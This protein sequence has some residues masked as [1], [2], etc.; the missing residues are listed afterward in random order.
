MTAKKK[1]AGG[2]LVRS[3]VVTVRLDPKLKFAAELAARKQRRTLSSFI[4][5]AIEQAVS[6]VKVTSYNGDEKSVLEATREIWDVSE[7]QRFLNFANNYSE[8]LNYD[9]E[10]LIKLIFLTPYFA[11]TFAADPENETSVGIIRAEKID[12]YWELLNKYVSGEI[13]RDDLPKELL[14]REI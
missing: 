6:E 2:S 14:G 13:N 10:R 8:L 1:S 7:A 11:E 3:Q 5:W 4:E 9:E 12:K